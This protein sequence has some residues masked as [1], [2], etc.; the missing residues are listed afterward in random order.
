MLQKLPKPSL[1]FLCALLGMGYFN[2][3]SSLDINPILKNYLALVPVQI[4]L[5]IYFL[6]FRRDT[7]KD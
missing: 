3:F 4:G 1:Y 6:W 2:A 7:L 5:V